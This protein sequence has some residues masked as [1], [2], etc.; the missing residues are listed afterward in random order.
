MP[1][2]DQS[3]GEEADEIVTGDYVGFLDHV[4]DELGK[5]HEVLAAEY[6]TT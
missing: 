6:F 1:R 2:R 5:T 3:G 4:L